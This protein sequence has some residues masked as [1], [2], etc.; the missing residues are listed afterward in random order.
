[1]CG[2]PISDEKH[3][4]RVAL[5]IWTNPDYYQAVKFTAQMLSEHGHQIDI[6]CRN[7]GEAFMGDVDYSDHTRV[8]RIGMKRPGS[9]TLISQVSCVHLS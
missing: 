9:E 1:M 8:I 7:T 6:L 4:M 3:A 5:V 2:I